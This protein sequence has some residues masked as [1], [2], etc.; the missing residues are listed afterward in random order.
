MLVWFC[1]GRATSSRP[2][3]NVSKVVLNTLYSIS[4]IMPLHIK[5]MSWA[6]IFILRL[7]FPPGK[8]IATMLVWLIFMGSNAQPPDFF[9][10]LVCATFPRRR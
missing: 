3:R 10:N 8:S 7:R 2:Q 5:I 1:C 6:L 4:V 9:T